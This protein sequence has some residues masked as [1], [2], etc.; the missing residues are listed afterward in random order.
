[1][2]REQAQECP[3]PQGCRVKVNPEAQGLSRVSLEAHE[4]LAG[5]GGVSKAVA[6]K[7]LPEALENWN[8]YGFGASTVCS[9]CPDVSCSLTL[10]GRPAWSWA[11]LPLQVLHSSFLLCTDFL[12]REAAGQFDLTPFSLPRPLQWFNTLLA[13]TSTSRATELGDSGPG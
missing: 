9:G 11:V 8:S 5:A 10:P 13:L 2:G 3:R 1:M 6:E 4:K 12:A 7:G